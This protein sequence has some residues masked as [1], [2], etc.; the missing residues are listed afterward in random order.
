MTTKL[1]TTKDPNCLECYV[2]RA[3]FGI[4]KKGKVMNDRSHSM[5]PSKRKKQFNRIKKKI[6][7]KTYH[8]S[9]RGLRILK[10]KGL[11][12]EQFVKQSACK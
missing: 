7:G 1:K 3:M 6:D 12:L 4:S 11:T 8:C 10:K 9:A 2:M 5:I